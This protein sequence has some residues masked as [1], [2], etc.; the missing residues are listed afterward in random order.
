MKYD[1][2]FINPLG[3][4]GVHYALEASSPQEACDQSPY[5][6]AVSSHWRPD[7]FTILSAKISIYENIDELR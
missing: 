2:N 5:W 1:I 7:Q 6:L 3:N 4:P